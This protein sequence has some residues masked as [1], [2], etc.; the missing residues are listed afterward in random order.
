MM[1]R[2]PRTRSSRIARRRGVAILL[3]LVAVATATVLSGAYIM[4]RR[5]APA[6]GMNAET[7]SNAKWAARSGSNLAI[8]MLETSLVTGADPEDQQILSGVTFGV[9]ESNAVLTS[10]TGATISP[11][12]HRLLVTSIGSASTIGAVDQR[13]LV[14]RPTNKITEALDPYLRDLAVF[15]VDRLRIQS[16]SYVAPWPESERGPS[17]FTANVGVAFGASGQLNT[18]TA[19]SLAFA[20]LVVDD[21]A[22]ASLTA[23]SQSATFAG[24]VDTG[25]QLPTASA[26]VPS[27]LTD[28]GTSAAPLYLW[29]S[30]F[31]STASNATYGNVTVTAGATLIFDQA[32]HSEY[33]VED[34]VVDSG[35]TIRVKGNVRILVRDDFEVTDRSSF[36]LADD[37][38]SVEVYVLDDL[39]VTNS[40]I[41]LPKALASNTSRS[42]TN[43]SGDFDASAIRIFLID[44]SGGGSIPQNVSLS[45]RAMVVGEIH[46][47]ASTLVIEHN[48]VVIGRV[49]GFDVRLSNSS[50]VFYDHKL[51][52]GAGVANPLGPMYDAERYSTLRSALA[53]FDNTL[54]LSALAQHIV[55]EFAAAGVDPDPDEEGPISANMPD[56]RDF[57]KIVL[58]PMRRGSARSIEAGAADYGLVSGFVVDGASNLGQVLSGA[59][60]GLRSGTGG[61]LR[62]LTSVLTND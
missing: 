15:A 53:S 59:A 26:R 52:P 4:S 12:E 29:S 49:A 58:V 7:S 21:D 10:I 16:G 37:D 27:S 23:V 40:V 33:S 28:L 35:S 57:G 34:L 61:L 47:P 3:V 19:G 43:L 46:A 22:T 6:L 51:N 55:D 20:V 25:V 1:L 24:G 11:D 14:R 50:T 56:P 48:S 62:D 38:S 32:N 39:T 18:S 54:G 30:L 45:S 9:G 17:L 42:F 36:E 5:A 2:N 13:V 41:G 60:E 8:A 44:P 31:T